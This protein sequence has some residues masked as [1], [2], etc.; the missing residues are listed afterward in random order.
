MAKTVSEV[1]AK[2][3]AKLSAIESVPGKDREIRLFEENS[4]TLPYRLYLLRRGEDKD[5]RHHRYQW[6]SDG[7][8]SWEH[9][10][11]RHSKLTKDDSEADSIAVRMMKE[12]EHFDGG[13]YV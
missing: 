9:I 1:I 12:H 13:Y 10:L 8:K 2:D 6:W 3:R 4:S 11:V 5:Y 7:N